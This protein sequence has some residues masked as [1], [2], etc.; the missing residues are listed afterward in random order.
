MKKTTAVPKR[1]GKVSRI[2]NR[3]ISLTFERTSEIM[4]DR[5]I[6]FP[7]FFLFLVLGIFVFV[8]A[9]TWMDFVQV[10]KLSDELTEAKYQA[11]ILSQEMKD[12]L[13]F[14]RAL[15]DNLAG[16]LGFSPGGNR[17]DYAMTEYNIY[18][19]DSRTFFG[20]QGLVNVSVK[21]REI[22]RSTGTDITR[23][24]P[25]IWPLKDRAGY[26]SSP[27][28]RIMDPFDH[29]PVFHPGIDICTLRMGDPVVVTADGKVIHIGFDRRGYGKYIIVLHQY[30]Y[31][32]LYGHLLSIDVANYQDVA[33]GDTIGYVGDSGRSTGPHLHYEVRLQ[34]TPMNPTLF[35]SLESVPS[36]VM[37]NLRQSDCLFRRENQRRAESLVNAPLSSRTFVG[38]SEIGYSLR[39]ED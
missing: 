34:T 2:L 7:M 8:I 18:D 25:G 20:T 24:I 17:D 6:R 12:Y 36:V 4:A 16:T 5:T 11:K 27:Y 35:M 32:T 28:G 39:E 21:E 10:E 29:V 3:P 9:L 38:G 1:N 30:G 22:A 37:S 33:R 14:S 19:S 26:I 15:T 31:M 23:K 13:L